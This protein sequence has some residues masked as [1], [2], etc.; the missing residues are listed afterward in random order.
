MKNFLFV[1]VSLL[2]MSMF[3]VSCTKDQDT[4]A[5][6]IAEFKINNA[7]EEVVV[8]AGT[9]MNIALTFTDNEA[10]Q[11]WKLDI[12]DAFD[13]HGHGKTQANA[14]FSLQ[15]TFA[16]SGATAQTTQAVNIP[17]NAAA[18]PYHC[19][20]RVLDAKGNESEFAEIDFI[21]TNAG[22]PVMN[23][24]SPDL[25]A[26]VE[27][28]KGN[29]LL[30]TGSITDDTDLVTVFIE[31][32][33]EEEDHD[34]GKTQDAPIYSMEWELTGSADTDW[35]FNNAQILIPASTATGHYRLL[36]TALDNDDNLTIKE[37]EVHVE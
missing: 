27:V 8:A 22:Q 9:A 2:A 37:A 19:I 5:P 25:N 28:T 14:R 6:Q 29:P 17:A 34:H 21:I 15:Q 18:G 36:I 7:T 32:G 11:E 26:E 30:I 20:I 35:N 4:E 16:I 33:E 24:T 1:L 3:T 10:L 31:L 12:H 13:G 23:I